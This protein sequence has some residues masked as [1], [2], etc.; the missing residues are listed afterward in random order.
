LWEEV[1]KRWNKPM[2]IEVVG[3]P[4]PTD[5]SIIFRGFKELPV[6]INA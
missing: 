2:Q 1:L 6:R 4:V 3:E 5:V